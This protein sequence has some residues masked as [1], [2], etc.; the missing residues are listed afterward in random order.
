MSVASDKYL[1]EISVLGGIFIDTQADI[2]Q[3][4]DLEN[5]QLAAAADQYEVTMDE[6]MAIA[7]SQAPLSMCSI[8][9]SPTARLLRGDGRASTQNDRL[10][11][12]VILSTGTSIHA[13][14]TC[15]RRRRD[16]AGIDPSAFKGEDGHRRIAGTAVYARSQ[17]TCLVHTPIHM[18][19][20]IYTHV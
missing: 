20:H 17:R 13:Q 14:W 11:E 9:A 4:Y 3:S 18:S 16:R 19:I 8:S 5:Q 6:K 15:R 7:A 12:A 10:S 1:P 2:R